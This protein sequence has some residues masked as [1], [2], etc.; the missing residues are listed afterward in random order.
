MNHTLRRNK[1]KILWGIL[2]VGN[3][4]TYRQLPLI[5]HFL[6][7]SQI[8]IFAS[9]SAYTFYSKKYAHHPHVRVLRVAPAYYPDSKSGIDFAQVEKLPINT[10]ENLLAI[11]TRALAQA[12]KIMGKPDLVISD[13]EPISAMYAYSQNSPLIT[14]DQQS[15]YLYGDFPKVIKGLNYLGEDARLRMFFPKADLRIACSFFR[16]QRRENF[17]AKV[18]ICPPVLRERILHMKRIP[19]KDTILIYLSA[20]E[21]YKRFIHILNEYSK[22]HSTITFHIFADGITRLNTA[23]K[24]IILHEPEGEKFLELLGKCSGIISTSG[25]TLVSEAMYLGIPV[26][27]L[28]RNQYE[29]Y[30]VTRIITQNK[31]G[32]SHHTLSEK[33]ISRFLN[34]LVSYQRNIARDKKI[35]LR[36][37]GQEIIIKLIE[38]KLYS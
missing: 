17:S 34:N 31:F 37:P 14:I 2:G 35:L 22:N 36:K 27:L 10:A 23:N 7:N 24:H 5:E 12:Q 8:I 3:G 29:A 16:V 38:K 18:T 32:I 25:H 6:K 28:P 15:K 13:Y 21:N 26:L 19:E 4:H 1:H 11:N 20:I 9:K 33:V 30:M